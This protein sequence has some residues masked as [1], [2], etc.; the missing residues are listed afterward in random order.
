MALGATERS[1]NGLAKAD[2]DVD[3]FVLGAA[4]G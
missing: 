4:A 1:R 3:Q 2:I